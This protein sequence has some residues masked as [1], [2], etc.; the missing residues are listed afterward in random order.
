MYDRCWCSAI[1]DRCWLVSA[2]HP[3][4]ENADATISASKSDH[5]SLFPAYCGTRAWTCRCTEAL[6]IWWIPFPPKLWGYGRFRSRRSFGDMGIPFPPKALR[7][8]VLSDGL[9]CF[10]AC[11]RHAP[12]VACSRWLKMA[13]SRRG[14]LVVV[15]PAPPPTPL[16]DEQSTPDVVDSI[17]AFAAELSRALRA[18]AFNQAFPTFGRV[19]F[20][21]PRRTQPPREEPIG[22]WRSYYQRHPDRPVTPPPRRR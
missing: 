3:G 15:C 9:F 14:R 22:S 20:S 6:G 17:D 8:C 16:E 7:S 21:P 2:S 10:G 5:R 11:A 1:D 12:A 4:Q 18:E 19:G 13:F